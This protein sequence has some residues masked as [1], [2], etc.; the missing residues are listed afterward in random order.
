[1]KKGIFG[2]KLGTPID[3]Y[4]FLITLLIVGFF[5]RIDSDFLVSAEVS[6]KVSNW[7]LCISSLMLIKIG[8]N[9]EKKNVFGVPEMALGA[10]QSFIISEYVP[11]NGYWSILYLFS[12]AWFLFTF[13]GGLLA[14]TNSYFQR[15]NSKEATISKTESLIVIIT[16]VLGCIFAGIQL[17]VQ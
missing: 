10:F 16:S 8:R 12:V 15:L 2:D 9:L 14:L 6:E 11:Q 13:I 1:M 7:C 17:F 4:A 3:K 5:L